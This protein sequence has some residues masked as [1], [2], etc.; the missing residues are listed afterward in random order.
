[1]GLT[2]HVFFN[3]GRIAWFIQST[4]VCQGWLVQRL[5]KQMRR[6]GSDREPAIRQVDLLLATFTKELLNRIAAIGE[7]GGEGR[8]LSG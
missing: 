4:V 6:E 5:G 8:W 2:L 3:F 1:M 7:G